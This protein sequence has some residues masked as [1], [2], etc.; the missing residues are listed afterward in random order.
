MQVRGRLSGRG[1]A[2]VLASAALVLADGAASA[3]PASGPGAL[4]G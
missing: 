4:N 3:S 2:V 1:A